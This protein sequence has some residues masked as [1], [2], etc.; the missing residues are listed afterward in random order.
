MGKVLTIFLGPRF[1]RDYERNCVSAGVLLIDRNL[2]LARIEQSQIRETGFAK[3]MI[4]CMSPVID[5]VVERGHDHDWSSSNTSMTYRASD[6][7]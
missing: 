4:R 1:Q 3:E 6:V 7:D 5:S 2:F